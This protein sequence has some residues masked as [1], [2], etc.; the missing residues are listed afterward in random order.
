MNDKALKSL[1]QLSESEQNQALRARDIM[2]KNFVTVTESTSIKSAIEILSVKNIPSV[3]VV[4]NSYIIIGV[5]S[6]HD[7]LIQS[8]SQD[9][10]EKI[11]F[12][13]D[14]I[15]VSENDPLKTVLLKILKNK[16][17]SIPVE[18]SRGELVGQI[19]RMGLLKIL[20]KR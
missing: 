16:L 15:T 7:L 20:I 2:D 4:N 18:S 6:E 12:T 13:K 1:T 10:Q 11:R 9:V 19:S 3:C 5:I 14:V 8:A 17:K